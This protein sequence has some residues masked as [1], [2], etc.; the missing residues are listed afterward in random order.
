MKLAGMNGDV[1]Y[2]YPLSREHMIGSH[3][4]KYLSIFMELEYVVVALDEHF[5]AIQVVLLYAPAIDAPIPR[6]IHLILWLHCLVPQI[7][8]GF[9]HFLGVIPRT[10]FGAICP[11]EATHS[12]VPP[13]QVS[14]NKCS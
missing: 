13:M 4:I 11:Q 5:P 14:G 12:F 7:M 9:I 2:D 8:H 10:K 3:I 1:G 6:H